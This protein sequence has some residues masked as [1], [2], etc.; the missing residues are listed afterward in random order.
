MFLVS[1]DALTS[2]TLFRLTTDLRTRLDEAT[3]ELGT[4]YV[5][6]RTEALR[7]NNEVLLRAQAIV[8][9]SQPELTRLTVIE[10]R[11]QA[12]SSALRSINELSGEAARSAQAAQ[13][14]AGDIGQDVAAS[15]ARSVLSSVL[16]TLNTQF[17]GRSLFAGDA[18]IGAA[19]TDVDSFIA[20]ADG[21]IAGAG[22]AAAQRA[23]LDTE[24]AAGGQ[25]DTV[26]YSGGTQLADLDLPGGGAVDALPTA[27]NDAIR[28]L[29][30]GLAMV[31]IN[32][33]VAPDER[34]QWLSDGASVIQTARD[35]LTAVEASLG[36]SQS[37]IERAID[38]Q[39]QILFD[40]QTTIDSLIGVDPFESVS[41]TQSLE[42]RLQA[43]YTVTGRT[44]ALR[45]TNFL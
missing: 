14:T 45:L 35:D 18:G 26:V 15:E 32:D 20:W 19:V 4:G 39:D 12:S 29:L 9:A 21:L 1:P 30:K 25:S 16:S 41:E 24:F 40:A 28:E 27:D 2:S 3:V 33:T 11:Y 8:D 22:D 10:G 7:G 36:I 5:Q 37:A 43:L 38:R 23:I 34:E 42:A 31:A 17:G 44:A 13:E 6:N